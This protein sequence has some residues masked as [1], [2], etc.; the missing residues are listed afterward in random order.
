MTNAMTYLFQMS[1]VLGFTENSL[2]VRAAEQF[3]IAFVC[4]YLHLLL[5]KV[6]LPGTTGRQNA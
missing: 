6:A 5:Q 2:A 4:F 3:S 1:L